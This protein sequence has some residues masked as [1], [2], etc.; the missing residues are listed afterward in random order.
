MPVVAGVPSQGGWSQPVFFLTLTS[1][2]FHNDS[3]QWVDVQSIPAAV[4]TL[5]LNLRQLCFFL[6]RPPYI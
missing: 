4:S 2:L 5:M 3:S 1:S 6:L